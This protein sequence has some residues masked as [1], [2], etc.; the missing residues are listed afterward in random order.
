MDDAVVAQL[1]QL[2]ALK[3]AGDIS[4]TA[5][6]AA[7][8][9]AMGMQLPLGPSTSVVVTGPAV[10]GGTPAGQPQPQPQLQLQQQ[11]QQPQPQLAL[12]LAP[13]GPTAQQL[14]AQL[15]LDSLQQQ[16]A[17]QL[18]QMQRQMQEH[19]A[20]AQAALAAAAPAP[21][22]HEQAKPGA[23]RSTSS[24]EKHAAPAAA[25][26]PQKAS[27]KQSTDLGAAQTASGGS[28]RRASVVMF[29]DICDSTAMSEEVRKVLKV[30]LPPLLH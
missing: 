5:W 16:Q 23:T 6:E 2:R 18:E 26:A 30:L 17:A 15:Q 3:D 25:A 20:A 9:N 10:F 11:P 12:A 21:Q 24:G 13:A 29:C 22:I 4:Q 19:M 1:R 28:E 14:A 7:Q 27:E 8:H